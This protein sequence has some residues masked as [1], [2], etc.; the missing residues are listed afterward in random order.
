VLLS[1]VVARF[2][3]RADG[4]AEAACAATVVKRLAMLVVVA[5]AV[6]LAP[7]AGVKALLGWRRARP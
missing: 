7:A 6:G 1:I 4:I 3:A 2:P 5:L